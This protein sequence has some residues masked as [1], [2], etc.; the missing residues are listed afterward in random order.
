M[1]TYIHCHKIYRKNNQKVII[2]LLVPQDETQGELLFKT[3]TQCSPKKALSHNR[4]AMKR[5]LKRLN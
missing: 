2:P 4:K 3:P 5:A 1:S